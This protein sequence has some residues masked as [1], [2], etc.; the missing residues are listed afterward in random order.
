MASIM[1]EVVADADPRAAA[2]REIG[3]SR[4]PLDQSVGPALGA[5]RFGV[6]EPSGIAVDT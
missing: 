4:N 1:G 2:E 3:V 6:V 5:E